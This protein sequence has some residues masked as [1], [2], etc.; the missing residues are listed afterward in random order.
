LKIGRSSADTTRDI[1][2]GTLVCRNSN[3]SNI[4]DMKLFS[5]NLEGE[6]GGENQ[7]RS[8]NKILKFFRTSALF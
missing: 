8:K 3:K 2:S 1:T 6:E 4:T 5:K 7:T